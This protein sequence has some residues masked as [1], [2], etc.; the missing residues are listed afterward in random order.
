NIE[1]GQVSVRQA[2]GQEFQVTTLALQ[3]ALALLPSGMRADVTSL[4]FALAGTGIP[5]LQWS[6]SLSYEDSGGISRV[7]LQPVEVRTALSHL[8]VSGTVDKLAAPTLALTVTMEKL[9]AADLGVFL[10]APRLQQDLSGSARVSGPLSALQVDVSLEA[11]N[12]RVTT[13]VTADLSQTPPSPQGTL[14]IEHLVVDKVLQI[15]D[16][17]GELNGQVSFQG[18][19]LETLHAT[20]N[21]QVS[22]LLAYG[23]QIDDLTIAGNLTKG[24]AAFTAEA[25]GRAGSLSSQ[26]KLSLD[27]PLV[28]ETTLTARHLNVAQLTGDKSSPATNMNFDVWVKGSG[29]TLEEI[30]SVAKLTVLPSQLGKLTLTQG[31]VEGALRKGQLTLNKGILLA[32]DTTVTAQGQIGRLQGTPNSKLSY[33]VQTKNLA[34]WLALA[35]IT[36]EGAIN[37]SGTAGGAL[38]ALSV[39]GKVSLSKCAVGTN[40]L[41]TGAVTYT[42][43]DI[44]SPRPRG[45]VTAA[46]NGLRA[47]LRL[48][49]VNADITLAGL[50]P[51][52]VQTEVTAQDEESRT[53]RVKMQTRYDSQLVDVLI[54]ELALQLPS[55]TW[56]TPQQPHLVFRDGTL[57]IEN[58][59]LWRAEQIV[60]ASGTLAQQGPLNLQVQVSRFSLEELRPFLGDEPAVSGRV[61]IDLRV[62]GTATNPDVTANIT[63]GAL[64]VA[65]Q[66]Y[67][68]L[69]AQSSYRQ[70]RLDLDLLLRQDDT[71][72]LNVEGGLPIALRGAG[73][74]PSPVLGE[75]NLR[76][77][78]AGLSLAFLS[79]LSSQIQGVQGTASM[80]V[81]LRGPVDALVPSGPVQIQQGQVRVKSLGQAFTDITVEM[82]LAQDAVRL[83]QFAVHA[84]EGQFTGRG[85]VALQQY[86]V[87]NIDLTFAAD[88][89]RVINTPQ[90]RAALSGQ[91]ACSGSLQQPV[92]KG[93]FNLVDTTARPDFALMK[94]GPAAP[95]P[96]ILVVQNTQELVAPAH[97]ESPGAAEQAAPPTAPPQNDLYSHLALDLTVTIPRDTWVH[98]KEG[99]IELTGQLRAQKDPAAELLLVGA[100]ETV[101]GWYEFYGRK[102]RLEQGNIVFTGATPI[103]P[104]LDV[105]ARYTLPGYQVD[106]IVGG[107]AKTPTVTFRSEPQLEQAD[108]LSLLLFGKPANALS[109]GEKVSLQSQ[110]MQAVVGSVAG[111]LQQALSQKLGVDNLELDVGDSSGQSKV[112]VGK[113]VAPGVFVSTS[114]QL[115]GEKPGQDVSIEYQLSDHWQL[116]ASTTSR[117]NNGADILWKKRY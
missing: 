107:T 93:A 33:S 42:L 10:P 6:S 84:G 68:G 18:A 22:N 74:A 7:S 117:G 75:A 47:G 76:V 23:R 8:Q 50:H 61:N 48:R 60:S 96:T 97:S 20:L 32:N 73:N 100:I 109:K 45:H 105:V 40:S 26:G 14:Q 13:A 95:D 39:E 114:Q 80:D 65:G 106:V 63:T 104:G 69:S 72:T 11:P 27:H 102:F 17:A 5:A 99:T 37:L 24:Q 112:G 78:S 56:H 38:T 77:R 81:R 66:S 49:T 31:Q 110:A 53:Q 41:Q 90:Y 71:H 21:A 51:A 57:S 52:E 70:E 54:Q 29:T 19:S 46:L 94:S 103:D 15:P 9:A 34:P 115:G 4:S 116:K 35:G 113:Y 36:G 2:D 108:I 87:T 89:F 79:L 16:I 25:K 98:L 59:S 85:S 44:G 82:Q 55:G 67:A 88:R 1:N 92:V 86:R 30:D 64:T 58:F 91:L 62:Q 12:G 28:Y 83:T 101:R 43:T 3:G 111:E